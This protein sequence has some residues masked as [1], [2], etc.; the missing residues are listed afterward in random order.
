MGAVF[1]HLVL[2]SVLLLGHGFSFAE[3]VVVAGARSQ[4]EHMTHEEVINIYM[5]RYRRLPNG[6]P[7]TPLDQIETTTRTEFYRRLINKNLSEVNA[8]WSRLVF[9]GK[10]SP[11]ETVPSSKDVAK[12]LAGSPN[13]IAYVDR[14][15]VDPRLKIIF[16][17]PD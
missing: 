16:E 1:K 10:A 5:G 2:L 14:R 17:F 13:T 11:P 7:A 8:Y 12:L 4:I 9:S 6:L 3:P 15:E